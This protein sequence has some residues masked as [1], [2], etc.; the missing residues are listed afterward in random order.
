MKV[1][2]SQVTKGHVSALAAS[3]SPLSII[4]FFLDYWFSR[5]VKVFKASEIE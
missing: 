4:F 1:L 3:P 2:A 5:T